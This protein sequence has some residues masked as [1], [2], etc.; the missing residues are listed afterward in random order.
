MSRPNKKTLISR[1]EPVAKPQRPA[2]TPTAAGA[3]EAPPPHEPVKIATA[4][5]ELSATET[6]SNTAPVVIAVKDE[7]PKTETAAAVPV[8][9]GAMFFVHPQQTSGFGGAK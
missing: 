5:G 1:D 4:V 6:R 9:G 8:R 3:Q 7:E 2:G